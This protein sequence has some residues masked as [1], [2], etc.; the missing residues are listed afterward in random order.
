MGRVTVAALR[1][2]AARKQ[3]AEVMSALDSVPMNFPGSGAAWGYPGGR[4]L[5]RLAEDARITAVTG[6]PG[7]EPLPDRRW[8]GVVTEETGP[9]VQLL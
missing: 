9:S 2:F 6:Q 3:A 1:S 4:D 5:E 7:S 8:G